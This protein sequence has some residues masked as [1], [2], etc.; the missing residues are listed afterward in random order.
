VKAGNHVSI[1]GGLRHR[2]RAVA[3][4][5]CAAAVLASCANGAT[6]PPSSTSSTVAGRPTTTVANPPARYVTIG[7]KRIRVP[8][9]KKNFP[10]HEYSDTGQQVIVSL[11]RFVPKTLYATGGTIV[12][13][14]L[15]SS[16]ETI[17]FLDYP[18]PETPV[19]SGPIPPGGTFRL[20]I[21]HLVA[22]KY[23]GSNGSFGYLNVE[24]IPGV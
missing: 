22:L 8:T 16:T 11:H 13:T 4:I 15:T 9:E 24:T 5:I 2:C 7:G 14:N 21:S 23:V 18:D 10:I 20:H 1:P 6:A 19:R 3:A 17:T 12:F